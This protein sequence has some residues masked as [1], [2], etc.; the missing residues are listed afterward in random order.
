MNTT[1][2]LVRHCAALGQEPDAPLT[3]EGYRQAEML[4][5]MLAQKSIGRI[6]SS[7]FVRAYE[8][9]APFAKRCGLAIE[10]DERLCERVLCG[11]A[12]DDWREA[13]QASF[14]DLDVCLPGGESSRAAMKR[15]VAAVTEAWQDNTTTV[16]VTH[17]NLL[18][19]I[20]RHF[21]NTVGF[22]EWQGLSNPDVF[23]VT[24]DTE[25]TRF[26]RIR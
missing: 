19:L 22:A 6:V 17:G 18:A 11:A 15:G 26:E 23:A 12:R 1:L 10:T 13:L 2:Y 4:A 7:P 25:T 16:V 5:Q 14:A 3:Q 8:T 24:R 21:D 20:L 9:I